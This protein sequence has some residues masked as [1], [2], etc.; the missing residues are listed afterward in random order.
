[1]ARL[2][3]EWSALS[4]LNWIKSYCALGVVAIAA[5]AILIWQYARRRTAVCRSL[6]ATAALLVVVGT[7]WIP[8]TAAFGIQ[9]R[10]SRRPID[11]ASV[12]VAFDSANKSVARALI[13]KGGRVWIDLPLQITEIPAGVSLRPDGLTVTI[14]APDGN[15]WRAE[16]PP[17]RYVITTGQVESLQTT[18]T[19]RFYSKVKDQAVRFRGSLYLTLYGNRRI[20][21][22]PLQNR[23]VVTPGMGLCSASRGAEGQMCFLVCISAFRGRPDLVSIRFVQPGEPASVEAMTYSP[24]HVISYS[25]FPAE[26]G[27]DPVSPYVTSLPYSTIQGPPSAARVATLEPLAHIRRDFDIGGLRLSEFEARP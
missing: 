16:Q 14:E 15:A 3:S 21:D 10:L 6:A 1:V 22:I 27:I 13:E 18:V 26:F 25:P 5:L 11:Q 12:R 20:T 23:P 24:Q 4:A 7:A 17:S 9:S 19:E 8:W 2:G